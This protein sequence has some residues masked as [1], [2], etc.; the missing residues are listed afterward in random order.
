MLNLAMHRKGA[1]TFSQM[2]FTPAFYVHIYNVQKGV[3]L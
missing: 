3:A 1:V 2:K